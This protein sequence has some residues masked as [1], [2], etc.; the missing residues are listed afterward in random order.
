MVKRAFGRLSGP[1]AAS[2]QT[3]HTTRIETRGLSHLVGGGSAG[4]AGAGDPAPATT[5]PIGH[6]TITPGTI[7]TIAR[8]LQLIGV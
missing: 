7:G 4:R 6:T 2:H 8:T 5:G 3:F 1:L